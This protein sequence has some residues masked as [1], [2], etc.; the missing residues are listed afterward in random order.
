MDENACNFCFRPGK[1]RAGPED[2]L[3]ENEYVCDSCW[4]LLQDPITA[5][6]LIRGNITINL[7]NKMP[8]QQLKKLTNEFMEKLSKLKPMN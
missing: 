2:G 4:K 7:R 5:L 6:P 8:E 3:K 1:V